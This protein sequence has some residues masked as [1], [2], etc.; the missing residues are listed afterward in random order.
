MIQSIYKL[1]KK[2]IL[3]EKMQ[4]IVYELSKV[5][6]EIVRSNFDCQ[7]TENRLKLIQ[8]KKNLRS[9]LEIKAKEYYKK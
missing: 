3:Y 1:S 6:K 7:I 8:K 5:G 2:E 9:K 4:N